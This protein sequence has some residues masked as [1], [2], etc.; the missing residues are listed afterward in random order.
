MRSPA[1]LACILALSSPALAQGTGFEEGAVVRVEGIAAGSV[2]NL[3]EGP[4]VAN[5]VL[6]T[7]SPGQTGLSVLYCDAAGAWCRIRSRIGA[8]GWASAAYL[9]PDEGAPPPPD[10][11]AAPA[12][13]A[14]FPPDAT[15]AVTGVQPGSALNVRAGPGTDRAV[16]TTV[17]AGRGGLDVLDCTATADWCEVGEGGMAL[18]WVSTR[19]L[20][21]E[22]AGGAP[23]PAMP[24][25][26]DEAMRLAAATGLT[27][28]P[29][30]T[31]TIPEL[32]P[33]LLGT[34]DA[35]GGACTETVSE[36]R[37]TVQPNGLV[38]GAATARFKNALFRENGYDLT[39]LLMQESDVP[40]AVPQR[41]LYRLEPDGD[42]LV[43]SGDVLAVQR[44][45][46]CTG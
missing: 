20:G 38:V 42:A 15:H 29:G 13:H 23:V 40:N 35:D 14:R 46:R 34:W 25:R 5:A 26:P 33:H 44:L 2:L 37:V 22:A 3:R 6:G 36:A 19:F 43:L 9:A 28:D 41:A 11:V 32:P 10:P 17:A 8:D 1:I 45:A 18:G 31:T 21:P 4:G 12:W 30:A 16:V 24:T 39:T 7:L 27:I